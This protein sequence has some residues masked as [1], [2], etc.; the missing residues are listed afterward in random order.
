MF[1]RTKAPTKE[2]E[3]TL[4]RK[5]NT[6]PKSKAESLRKLPYQREIRVARSSS[7]QSRPGETGRWRALFFLLRL[8]LRREKLMPRSFS[9]MLGLRSRLKTV[10]SSERR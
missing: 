10:Q 9:Y 4:T 7:Y 2:N 3:S 1:G 6:V 8:L 5:K